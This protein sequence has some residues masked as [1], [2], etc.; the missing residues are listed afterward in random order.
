MLVRPGY[1]HCCSPTGAA[2]AAIAH[3][4]GVPMIWIWSTGSA[5][6]TTLSKNQSRWRAPYEDLDRAGGNQAV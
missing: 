4:A 1:G 5:P 2:L 6:Y 3:E